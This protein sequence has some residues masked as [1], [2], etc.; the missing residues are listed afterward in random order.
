MALAYEESAVLANDKDI[1]A[2]LLI[3]VK[4]NRLLHEE[5]QVLWKVSGGCGLHDYMKRGFLIDM[6]TKTDS[7]RI[8]HYWSIQTSKDLKAQAEHYLF[9]L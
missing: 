9:S 6:G 4:M 3:G 2:A 7:A 1:E 5:G 8:P